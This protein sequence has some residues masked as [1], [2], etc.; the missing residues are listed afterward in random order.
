MRYAAEEPPFQPGSRLEDVKNLQGRQML[1][2]YR[3]KAAESGCNSELL[4]FHHLYSSTL[5][6]EIK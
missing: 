4:F 5:Q 1:A 3:K 6:E 2:D